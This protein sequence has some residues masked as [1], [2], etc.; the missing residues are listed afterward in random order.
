M[1]GSLSTPGVATLRLPISQGISRKSKGPGFENDAKPSASSPSCSTW[2]SGLVYY[3]APP[4]PQAHT[5][6]AELGSAMD[7]EQSSFILH[8]KISGMLGTEQA[9]SH[10]VNPGHRVLRSLAAVTSL[11]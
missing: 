2:M 3:R 6:T 5:R 11:G 1:N 10:S 9:G 4:P 7:W 8:W